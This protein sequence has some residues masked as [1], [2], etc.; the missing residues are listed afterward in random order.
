[1][2]YSYCYKIKWSEVN[3]NISTGC[4]WSL[5]RRYLQA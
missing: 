5:D 4:E 3:L 2:Q 1:M